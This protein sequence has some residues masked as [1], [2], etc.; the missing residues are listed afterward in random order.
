MLVLAGMILPSSTQDAK[1]YKYME[2]W[3]PLSEVRYEQLEN[4][5]IFRWGMHGAEQEIAPATGPGT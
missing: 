3:A 1:S 4:L 5:K 2:F